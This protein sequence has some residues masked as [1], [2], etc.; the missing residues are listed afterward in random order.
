[1]S[2]NL[3]INDW[4]QS[5][6]GTGHLYPSTYVLY[7]TGLWVALGW[8]Y[9]LRPFSVPLLIYVGV[10]VRTHGIKSRLTGKKPR[11]LLPAAASP[12]TSKGTAGALVL[13][14]LTNTDGILFCWVYY[15]SHLRYN[16]SHFLVT[17]TAESFPH[18]L[19]IWTS[20]EKGLV[21]CFRT[22]LG[23]IELLSGYCSWGNN[24]E[25]NKMFITWTIRN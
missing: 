14:T 13:G 21:K 12:Y 5:R 15:H 7:C 25:T 23:F 17:N 18:L 9:P 3:L 20:W 6:A 24:L 19:A 11:I 2:Q 22:R 10:G 1:M 16:W 4:K 8:H